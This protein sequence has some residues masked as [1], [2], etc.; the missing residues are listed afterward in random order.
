MPGAQAREGLKFQFPGAAR[1]K[2]RS[3]VE[4]VLLR[5]HEL[6]RRLEKTL[7]SPIQHEEGH[8]D[9]Q[10][11]SV[12]GEIASGGFLR[13]PYDERLRGGDTFAFPREVGL[14]ASAPCRTIPFTPFLPLRE[15][16]RLF[17]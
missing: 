15:A 12:G 4:R 14:L 11:K 3:I 2:L 8:E 7:Q 9:R 13:I 16:L 10:W 5:Q 6:I 1:R 17:F